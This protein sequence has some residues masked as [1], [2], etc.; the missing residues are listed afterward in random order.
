VV[1]HLDGVPVG[2]MDELHRLLRREL[3]GKAVAVEAL[4]A[5]R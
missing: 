2:G 5:G 1:V 3:A 4:R